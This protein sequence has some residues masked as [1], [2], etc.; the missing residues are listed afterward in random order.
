M[1]IY[2]AIVVC[3]LFTI[4]MV[5]CAC[6]VNNPY[7]LQAFAFLAFLFSGMFLTI[8]GTQVD[9]GNNSSVKKQF[10]AFAFM[11]GIML[12]ISCIAAF[13]LSKIPDYDPQIDDDGHRYKEGGA[14]QRREI[15][16]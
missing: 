8:A 4:G 7:C 3:A 15:Q 5:F 14:P 10:I 11:L 2:I 16:V 13:K 6:T 9:G 1:G 12:F